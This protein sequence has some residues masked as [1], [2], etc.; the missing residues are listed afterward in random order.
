MYATRNPVG[1]Q[2][3]PTKHFPNVTFPYGGIACDR[4]HSHF[5]S[6]ALHNECLCKVLSSGCFNVFVT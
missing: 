6:H 4:K 1:Q 5:L 3:N 2:T